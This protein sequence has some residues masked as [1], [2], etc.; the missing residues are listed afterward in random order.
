MLRILFVDDEPFILQGLSVLIDWEKEGFEIAGTAANGLEAIRF[1]KNNEVDLILADIRM[2]AMSGLELLEKLRTEGISDAYFIILSGYSDF[3]YARK[4]LQYGCM[5]YILKPVRKTELIAALDKVKA[6]SSLTLRKKEEEA[7]QE[8]A[9]FARNLIAII[10][11]KYDQMN[12]E[13]VT[14][15]MRTDGGIRYIDIEIDDRNEEGSEYE[16]PKTEEEK[17]KLQRLLYQSCLD[18]LG[19]DGWHCIFDVSSNER[20]YDIGLIYCDYMAQE[21][22]MNKQD[23]LDS[24]LGSIQEAIKHPVVMFVGNRVEHISGLSES[25]RTANIARSFQNFHVDGMNQCISWYEEQERTEGR[26]LLFKASLDDLARAVEQNDKE[27]IPGL[28]DHLYDEINQNAMDAKLVSLNI[29]YLLFQLVHLAQAQDPNVNQEEILEF[30]SGSAFDSGTMRGSRM[31]LKRFAEEYA[32]YLSQIRGKTIRG[33]V[34]GEVEQYIREHYSENLTLKE[35]GQNYY[36]NSA[37]LGQLF[38]KTYGVSFKDY[39]NNYRIEMAASFLLHTDMKNYEIME[40]VGYHDLD[41]F[42][43]KFIAAKGCTP[44]RFRKKCRE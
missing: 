31:H 10:C 38:R 25:Y 19:E 36:I 24:F 35:L 42:I 7:L 15:K 18:F 39:L 32:D 12:L 26:S 11:G 21:A 41:Y 27:R 1:L 16:P 23:Y 4:A 6:E 17:R 5:D 40:K 9:Y 34:L 22:G 44:A 43:N 20:D 14:A 33:G 3:E 13:Y 37:Y 28:V 30:I 2:P 8:K 29:D